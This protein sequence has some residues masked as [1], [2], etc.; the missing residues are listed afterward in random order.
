MKTKLEIYSLQ[1]KKQLENIII[2]N[3]K[4]KKKQLTKKYIFFQKNLCIIFLY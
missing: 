4:L 1:I 3:R 2:H